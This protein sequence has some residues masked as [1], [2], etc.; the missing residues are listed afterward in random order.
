MLTCSVRWCFD[1][2]VRLSL[3]GCAVAVSISTVSVVSCD[4]ICVMPLGLLSQEGIRGLGFLY[5]T[6]KVVE[7]QEEVVRGWECRRSLRNG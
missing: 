3:P 5:S 1:S 7:E 6:M 4:V 2:L